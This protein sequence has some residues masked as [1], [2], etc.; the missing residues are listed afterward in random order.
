MSICLVMVLGLGLACNHP[1]EVRLRVIDTSCQA[2]Q[3]FRWSVDDT[4]ETIE[5]ARQHN[6]VYD[7]LC[8][9]TIMPSEPDEIR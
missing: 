8:L 7:H 2:Y 9:D 5:Q 6:A 4:D 3:P 1:D